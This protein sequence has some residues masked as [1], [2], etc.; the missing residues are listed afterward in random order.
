MVLK[1]DFR[2]DVLKMSFHNYD[3]KIT[4]ILFLVRIF[5][6][7]IVVIIESMTRPQ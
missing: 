7:E 4:T 1:L 6:N 5:L 3:L 2:S